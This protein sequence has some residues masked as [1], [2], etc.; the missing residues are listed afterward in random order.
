MVLKCWHV[1]FAERAVTSECGWHRKVGKLLMSISLF[2]L[3]PLSEPLWHGNIQ[4]PI[5]ELEEEKKE[6]VARLLK[7]E[8]EM[9]EVFERKVREKQRKLTDTE[10]DLKLKLGEA[11]EKL[12]KQKEELDDKIASFERVSKKSDIENHQKNLI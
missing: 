4:S 8:K 7:M 1:C 2:S 12:D 11:Q 9:E 10:S 3:F 6:H 5:Q